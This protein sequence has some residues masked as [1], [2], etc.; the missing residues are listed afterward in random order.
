MYLRPKSQIWLEMY[1]MKRFTDMDESP[2]SM[3]FFLSNWFVFSQLLADEYSIY[4]YCIVIKD[5]RFLFK[6]KNY[7]SFKNCY[8]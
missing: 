7:P 6:S 1:Q 3:F 4:R 2:L 5:L 8:F